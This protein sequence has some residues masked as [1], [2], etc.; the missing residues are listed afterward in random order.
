MLVPLDLEENA[1]AMVAIGRAKGWSDADTRRLMVRAVARG[2][3]EHE[4]DPIAQERLL[5]AFQG[6]LEAALARPR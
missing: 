4:P 1:N 6:Y 2:I 3:D 5:A